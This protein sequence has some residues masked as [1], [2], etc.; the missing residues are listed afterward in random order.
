MLSSYDYFKYLCF[1]LLFLGGQVR[2]KFAGAEAQSVRYELAQFPLS[3][4]S[5]APST[6]SLIPKW[7]SAGAQGLLNV[8][9]LG[10]GTGCAGPS[11]SQ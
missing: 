2:S 1:H 5:P 6:G 10:L 7:S 4:Y 3:V 11:L 9:S 8:F